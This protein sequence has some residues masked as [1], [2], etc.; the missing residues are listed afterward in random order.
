MNRCPRCTGP[1]GTQPA[2]S[3][4]T[5]A[6]TVPVC[7]PCGRDEARR[8]HAGKPP[9]PPHRWP[10]PNAHTPETSQP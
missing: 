5:L 8:D 1:L 3:R 9:I 6:R 10:I 7:T 4:L 2:R